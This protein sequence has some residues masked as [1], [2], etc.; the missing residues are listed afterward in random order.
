MISAEEQIAKPDPAIYLRTCRR[1]GPM[2][3][4]CLFID[5]VPANVDG[6]RRA[7]FTLNCSRPCRSWPT[8]SV[9]I[10]APHRGSDVVF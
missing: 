10:L 9:A 7:G 8:G 5:D 2:P 1:L 4:E 6:A 3:A